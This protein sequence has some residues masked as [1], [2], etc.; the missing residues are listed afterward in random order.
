MLFRSILRI[1]PLMA[2]LVLSGSN[3]ALQAQGL[4]DKEFE[5]LSLKLSEDNGFFPT[6]NL[7]SNETS[8]LHVLPQIRKYVEPGQAYVGVGPEQNFSYIVAAKPKM[9]FIVDIRRDNLLHHLWLKSI[10]LTS[11]GRGE[12]MSQ[13]FGKPLPGGF[14]AGP[15]ADARDLAKLFEGLP[16]DKEFYESNIEKLWQLIHSKYPRLTKP[17]DR[18]TIERIASA[19]HRKGL[20]LAYEI[21]GRPELNARLFPSWGS[22]MVQTDLRGRTGHYLDRDE[23]FVFLKKLAEENRLIPVVGNLAGG[24]ALRTVGDELRR[25]DLKVSLLYTSNVEFYLFR[26]GTMD[27]FIENVGSMPV[28]E[29]GIIIRSYFNRLTGYR[30]IHPESIAGHLSVSLVQNIERFLQIAE[31]EPYRNYWDLVARDYIPS[32]P[33]PMPENPDR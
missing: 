16:A 23:S 2:L 30:D 17:D 26:N 5:E 27:Y 25:R 24:K 13:L 9:V 31:D 7:V 28:H 15:G 20:D 22:L 18:R 19:F 1:L 8:Y 32:H 11:E 3:C 12:F 29:K 6:D 33:I 10:F 21:P 14:K 4:S